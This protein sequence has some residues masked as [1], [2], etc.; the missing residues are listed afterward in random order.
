[1]LV[2]A[3]LLAALVVDLILYD[4]SLTL[5]RTNVIENASVERHWVTIVLNIIFG[6]F[7]ALVYFKGEKLGGGEMSM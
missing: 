4:T 5:M 1:M 2:L 7:D 6:A 3:I